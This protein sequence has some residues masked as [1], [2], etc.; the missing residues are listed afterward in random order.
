M[1]YTLLLNLILRKGVKRET[2][3]ISLHTHTHTHTHAHT[4]RG[5]EIETYF[6]EQMGRGGK[7]EVC[8]TGQQARNSGKVSRLRS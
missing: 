4:H 3:Q 7:S 2:N 6:R 1:C 8:R 5:R